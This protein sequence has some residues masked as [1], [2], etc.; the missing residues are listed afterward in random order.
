LSLRVFPLA[1]L[2]GLGWL[3]VTGED[4]VSCCACF[5]TSKIVI[6]F[7]CLVTLDGLGHIVKSSIF[8]QAHISSQE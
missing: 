7:G 4:I 8:E 3:F 6:L 1:A 2:L 5:T